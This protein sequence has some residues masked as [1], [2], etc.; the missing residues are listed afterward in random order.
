[1]AAS[2]VKNNARLNI[3]NEIQ[4]YSKSSKWFQ[5]LLIKNQS[6]NHIETSQ[7]TGFYSMATLVLNVIITFII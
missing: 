7:L 3:K 1:M 2:E 6:Y 4:K 5:S